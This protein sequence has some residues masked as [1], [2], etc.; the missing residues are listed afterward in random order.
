LL[1]DGL[2]LAS[3]CPLPVRAGVIIAPVTV[4]YSNH[5]TLDDCYINGS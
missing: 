3:W 4:A 1:A 5:R 2:A